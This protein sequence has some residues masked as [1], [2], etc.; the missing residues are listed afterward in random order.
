LGQFLRGAVIRQLGKLGHGLLGGQIVGGPAKHVS[1]P[2]EKRG[3]SQ[4][5]V[6][7]AIRG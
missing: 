4:L 6:H 1:N 2:A 3:E 7:G 5:I